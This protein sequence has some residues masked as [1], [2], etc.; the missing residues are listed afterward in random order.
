MKDKLWCN[1]HTK[2]PIL[3]QVF[4][5]LAIIHKRDAPPIARTDSTLL[6]FISAFSQIQFI[7]SAY[8]CCRDVLN[9]SDPI[10]RYPLGT[11]YI[12]LLSYVANLHRASSVCR[13]VLDSLNTP[14]QIRYYCETAQEGVLI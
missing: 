5:S 2:S 13:I 4:F 7:L 3:C 6:S 12:A 8:A 1:D 10:F 14:N 11:I 9:L